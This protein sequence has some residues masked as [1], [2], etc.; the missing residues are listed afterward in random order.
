M[1]SSSKRAQAYLV[2]YRSG[3][4]S[5]PE[6]AIFLEQERANKY[7]VEHRG[8]IVPLQEQLL[9]TIKKCSDPLAW[10]RNKMG[11]TYSVL[12]IDSVGVWTRDDEGFV[13]V[14]SW[15]DIE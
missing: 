12:G 3:E 13:N 5:R 8:T 15:K 10:Y 9:V 4:T 14:I 7:A 11:S 2:H 6:K 1:I